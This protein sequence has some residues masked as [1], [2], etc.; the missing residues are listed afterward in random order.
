V[1]LPSINDPLV[2]ITVSGLAVLLALLVATDRHV[3]RQARMRARFSHAFGSRR[4]ASGLEHAALLLSNEARAAFASIVRAAGV[5]RILGTGDRGKVRLLLQ[6]AGFRSTASLANF[7][8]AKLIA[9]ILGVVAGLGLVANG[10]FAG[11]GLLQFAVV[12]MGFFIGGLLPELVMRKVAARRQERVRIALPDAIDLLI[13]AANA[14]QSLEVALNRVGKEMTRNAP[15]LADEL[16][17]TTSELRALPNRREALENLALRTGIAEVRS[18][19]ATLIQTIKYGTPLT[20]SLKILA[21][22]LRQA[23]LL[24]LEEKAAKLPALLALP[25]MLLIM[26]SIFIVTAGPAV[27]SIGEALFGQ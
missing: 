3:Q 5:L 13:I 21:A 4:H 22:E 17:V 8:G 6:S 14:G 11:Q 10:T 15:E 1:K 25:L 26:P 2:L 20:Q 18:L 23:K 12:F 19:T 16:R 27:L 7:F 9:S 24:R